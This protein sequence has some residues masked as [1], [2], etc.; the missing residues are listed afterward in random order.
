[1][2]VKLISEMWEMSEGSEM[3]K[4][5]LKTWPKEGAEYKEDIAALQ[6]QVDAAPFANHVLVW[7]ESSPRSGV[8]PELHGDPAPEVTEKDRARAAYLNEVG[9]LVHKH[10]PNLRVEIG[11]SGASVGAVVRP[12]RVDKSVAECYDRVST[13][14]CA[15][16]I[17]PER[18]IDVGLQGLIIAR[19]AFEAIAGKRPRMNGCYEFAYR[20]EREL[21]ERRQ[22]EYYVRD[23]LVCLS[24]KFDLISPGVLY[25]V[26]SP[27]YST[28]WGAAGILLCEPYGYPKQAYVAY[29]A[30]TYALDGVKFVRELDTG[31]TTVY[32]PLF[33]RADGKYAVAL[34]C[35]RGEGEMTFGDLAGEV[36][37]MIGRT[38]PLKSGDA[39]AF[40]EEPTYVVFDRKPETCLYTRISENEA[41]SSSIGGYNN[42]TYAQAREIYGNFKYVY[43]RETGIGMKEL[44]DFQPLAAG[45]NLYTLK[46]L[47]PTMEKYAENKFFVYGNHEQ[48]FFKD[49][50]AYQPEYMEKEMLV[51]QTLKARGHRFV[52]MEELV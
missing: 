49:Y 14:I 17:P 29:G 52:F 2:N 4:D 7:H 46:T 47:L 16:T 13:E 28:V 30:L 19:D 23:L 32:A 38:H 5:F 15:Q 31:S 37:T 33:V 24:H 50:L 51:A 27:Y 6:K 34:W 20:P 9:R 43:D 35:A 1:M 42:L 21:G 36:R 10:F 22:A 3:P 45:I 41:I 8:P 12:L 25:D 11:N 44:E 18:L 48:Y 39:V 40:S 26:P